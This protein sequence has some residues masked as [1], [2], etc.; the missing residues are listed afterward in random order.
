MLLGT[1]LFLAVLSAL[2]I[3]FGGEAVFMAS[4]I[5]FVII[6]SILFFLL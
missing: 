4:N 5:L 3:K 1:L 2:V 6:S